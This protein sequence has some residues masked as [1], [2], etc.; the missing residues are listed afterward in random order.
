MTEYR[1]TRDPDPAWQADLERLAPRSDRNNW[2]KIH[3]FAG[4]DY[5]PIQRWR[6]FEMV[7]NPERFDGLEEIVND[8]KGMSPRDPDNGLWVTEGFK[9]LEEESDTVRR[10]WRSWSTVDFDQWTLYQETGCLAN[11]A[12][13]IQGSHGGHRWRLN[14]AELGVFEA[15]GIS[16]PEF[17]LPGDLPYAEYDQRTFVQLAEFDRLRQWKQ[18]LSWDERMEKNKAGLWVNREKRADE[19]EYNKALMKWID[20]QV[21]N[22]VDDLSR[23]NLPCPSDM[24][25]GDRYYNIDE[26]AEDQAFIEETATR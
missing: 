11:P 26:D 3:W 10:R 24:L 15:H 1:H 23:V 13:I 7:P 8:L 22:A 12:W 18:S 21:E 19:Q 4:W 14:R 17:P 25:Q 20:T 2:L 16:E 6:I 9:V 5:E